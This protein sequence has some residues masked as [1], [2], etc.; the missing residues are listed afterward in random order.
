MCAISIDLD[1]RVEEVAR[2]EDSLE[3]DTDSLVREGGGSDG[4]FGRGLEGV[5]DVGPDMDWEG[6][7]GFRGG[8]SFTAGAEP[9]FPMVPAG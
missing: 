9:Q 4:W 2:E 6:K 8:S 3:F 7:E 5:P 1:F